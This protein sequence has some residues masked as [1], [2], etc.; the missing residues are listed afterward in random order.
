MLNFFYNFY[1]KKLT[2]NA[3]I[4]KKFILKMLKTEYFYNTSKIT[5][6]N[7]YSKNYFI[8]IYKRES[9]PY[10]KYKI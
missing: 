1:F 8:K 3:L 10:Q 9:I 4:K 5:D 2:K 7:N 6:S